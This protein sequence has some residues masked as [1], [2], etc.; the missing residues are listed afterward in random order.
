MVRATDAP[1]IVFVLISWFV[2]RPLRAIE[3]FERGKDHDFLLSQVWPTHTAR[4]PD[5]VRPKPPLRAFTHPISQVYERLRNCR[6]RHSCR[7][8]ASRWGICRAL[9]SA[10]PSILI[11]R[12][13]LPNTSMNGSRVIVFETKRNYSHLYDEDLRSTHIYWAKSREHGT[14]LSVFST[15]YYNAISTSSL[16]RYE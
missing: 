8:D 15:H 7:I 1:S 11:A 9:E 16:A 14:I 3:K 2:V 10:G 12:T 13:L 5:S 4:R 6:G